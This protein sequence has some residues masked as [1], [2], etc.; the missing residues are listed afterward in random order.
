MPITANQQLVDLLIYPLYF[1]LNCIVFNH[2]HILNFINKKMLFIKCNFK[3]TTLYNKTQ[4]KKRKRK[5]DINK[6]SI[7]IL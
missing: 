7:L 2:C 4:T 1:S 6:K 3:V 5:E